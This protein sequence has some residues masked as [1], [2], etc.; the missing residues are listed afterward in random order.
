[1]PQDFVRFGETWLEHNPGWEMRTWGENDTSGLRNQELYDSARSFSEKSDVLRYEIL[2]ANGGIYI[3]C[4]FEC[5][6]PIEPLLYGVE[7]CAAFESEVQI[8]S[9][10]LGATPHHPFVEHLVSSMP[11]SIKEYGSSDPALSSGP[12]FVTRCL[13][14]SDASLRESVTLFPSSYFYPY[15]WEKKYRKFERFDEAFAVHHW[16]G[17]WMSPSGSQLK[18][19][20]RSLFMRFWI[21]R[22]YFYLYDWARSYRRPRWTRIR[23]APKLED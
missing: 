1:M 15:S 9:A 7:F 16:A 3:D 5:L 23:R 19:R 11:S 22:R 18:A 17:S 14:A 6:R 12:A 8:G 21:T 4:D 20:T 10:F 13:D 2:L